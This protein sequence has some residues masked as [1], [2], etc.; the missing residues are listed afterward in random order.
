MNSGTIIASGKA[1]GIHDIS[2]QNNTLT[3]TGEGN[4]GRITYRGT[5]KLIILA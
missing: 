3:A 1:I 5:G 2:I 4:R